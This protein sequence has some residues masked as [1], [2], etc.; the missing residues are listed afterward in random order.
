[1]GVGAERIRWGEM[2]SDR[3]GGGGEDRDG[4]GP[5][6]VGLMWQ[7]LKER[8]ETALRRERKRNVWNPLDLSSHAYNW[9]DRA[10]TPANTHTCKYIQVRIMDFFFITYYRYQLL[11][12]LSYFAVVTRTA[13]TRSVTAYFIKYLQSRAATSM[14]QCNALVLIIRL[15]WEKTVMLSVLILDDMWLFMVTKLLEYPTLYVPGESIALMYGSQCEFRHCHALRNVSSITPRQSFAKRFLSGHTHNPRNLYRVPF[16]NIVSWRSVLRRYNNT[17]VN[18]LPKADM[19]GSFL[20]HEPQ[21]LW[22]GGAREGGEERAA[23]G[24]FSTSDLLLKPSTLLS[25]YFM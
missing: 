12:Y 21:L 6:V 15:T 25:K 24:V 23:S 7:S 4:T 20:R 2:I 8:G 5:D 22:V 14:Y 9:I 19:R 16:T 1:M 10:C 17:R 18:N 11:T 3:K 13:N